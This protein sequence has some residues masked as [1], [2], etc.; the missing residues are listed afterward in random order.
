MIEDKRT[1]NELLARYE[2]EP[3]LRDVYVEG[4]FDCDLFR[5]S[6]CNSSD[7]TLIYNIDTVDIPT[8]LLADYG[9]TSGNKQRVLALAKE[10]ETNLSGKFN[11]I[12]LTDRDLD[13]WFGNLENIRNHN[14][15]K[16]TSLEM[17]FFNFEFIQHLLFN[18]C[19]TKITN[20]QQFYESLIDT[21]KKCFAFRCVLRDLS[22]NVATVSVDKCICTKNGVIDFKLDEFITK[23]LNKNGK[24]KHAKEVILKV[25]EWYKKF[26]VDERQCVRGHDFVELIASAVKRF[27]GQKE[28]ATETAIYRIFVSSVLNNSEILTEI[29]A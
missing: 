19:R 28:I 4:E 12:C 1:I 18:V 21:L 24:M 11:Y 29:A 2:L 14:W 27:G 5:S 3:E 22:L 16:F 15:T 17:Q 9:Y 7:G 8:S 26:N 23:T 13:H 25:D 20:Y 10:L 6:L